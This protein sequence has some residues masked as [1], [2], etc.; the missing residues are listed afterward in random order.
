M[1]VSLLPKSAGAAQ[2][3]KLYWR[4]PHVSARV[5]KLDA[6][7]KAAKTD[8]LGTRLQ[9]IRRQPTEVISPYLSDMKMAEDSQG[10]CLSVKHDNVED[11]AR[12][13]LWRDWI[14]R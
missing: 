5:P 4:P 3:L 2:T 9:A 8:I 14:D 11:G 7:W 10:G 13:D 6:M 12:L 1:C